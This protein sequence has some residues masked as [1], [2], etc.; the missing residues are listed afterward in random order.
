VT[1]YAIKKGLLLLSAGTYANVLRF[2]PAVVTSD[3]LLLD[4]VAIID[5]ALSAR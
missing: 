5:E 4:A 1:A 2:L 3:E